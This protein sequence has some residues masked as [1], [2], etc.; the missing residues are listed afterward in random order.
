MNNSPPNFGRLV[1]FCIE[2]D[3]CV[4]IRILKHFSRSTRFA[5]LCTAPDSKFQSKIA[6]LFS[7][8]NNEL[9]IFRHFLIE[10]CRF[11]AKIRWIFLG[12]SLKFLENLK[13]CRQ[14]DEIPEKMQYFSGNLQKKIG[15][16]WNYSI[17]WLNNS[18]A[19]LLPNPWEVP[20]GSTR[21]PPPL[22]PV[23]TVRRSCSN[24]FVH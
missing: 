22:S 21:I 17:F 5:N 8:M 7:K 16:L 9:F 20:T 4:Q 3:F 19:S 18:F 24:R 13:I 10:F 2:A 6:K 11:E 14:S 15:K 1:L 12:I 23:Y